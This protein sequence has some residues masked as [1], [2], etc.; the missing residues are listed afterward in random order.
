MFFWSFGNE[1]D[2]ATF[3]TDKRSVQ[4]VVN[5][6]KLEKISTS[7]DINVPAFFDTQNFV[8][9]LVLSNRMFVRKGSA[10]TREKKEL[11]L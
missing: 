5:L 11:L 9:P 1:N 7:F 3:L 10:K 4:F 8:H 2:P 6:R